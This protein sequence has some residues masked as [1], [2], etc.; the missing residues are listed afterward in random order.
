M[1]GAHHNL[2]DDAEGREIRDQ[3]AVL[4][5]HRRED[6]YSVCGNRGFSES[7]AWWW[8]KWI[9]PLG[10]HTVHSGV[11][12]GKRRYRTSGSWERYS[13]RMGNILFLTNA[14]KSSP[15]AQR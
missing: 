11:D 14:V 2:P 6:V 7:E 13:F 8:R 9:D 15:T 3:F 1:S 5:K 10:E 4:R 12:A